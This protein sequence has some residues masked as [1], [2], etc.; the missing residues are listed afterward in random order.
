MLGLGLIRRDVRPVLTLLGGEGLVGLVL[1]GLKPG[2]ASRALF[3]GSS[4]GRVKLTDPL[5]SRPRGWA[6]LAAAPEVHGNPIE[7][8]INGRGVARVHTRHRLP[9][10]L[11]ESCGVR[12]IRVDRSDRS[13]RH[14]GGGRV[15][16]RDE[17][18]RVHAARLELVERLPD[19]LADRRVVE[20]AEQPRDAARHRRGGCLRGP[21]RRTGGFGRE[22]VA[23]EHEVDEHIHRD[24]LTARTDLVRDEGGGLRMR[25]LG[26][27][28][29]PVALDAEEDKLGDKLRELLGRDVF[30]GRDDVVDVALKRSGLILR[31]ASRVVELL[32]GGADDLRE[33][34]NRARPSAGRPI[35]ASREK[36]PG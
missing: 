26:D 31:D 6:G 8:R 12:R 29:R 4:H 28:E 19:G 36:A 21:R 13:S 15:H 1:L 7:N 9:K 11:E 35:C 5:H 30:R 25:R 16:L 18:A 33:I 2:Y 14:R 27:P 17:L 23:P 32:C 10:R 24:E 34:S 20:K 22:S 3:Q